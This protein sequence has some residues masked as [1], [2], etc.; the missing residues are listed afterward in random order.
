MFDALV[1]QI[2]WVGETSYYG[3]ALS[4]GGRLCAS[5]YEEVLSGGGG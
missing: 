4:G 1:L 3:E 5:Y 2:D